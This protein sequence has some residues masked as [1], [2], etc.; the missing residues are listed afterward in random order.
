MKT[1]NL[2]YGFHSVLEALESDA[3]IDQIFIARGLEKKLI[4][5]KILELAKEKKVVVKEVPIEKLYSLTQK[6]HQGI[7]ATLTQITYASLEELVIRTYEKGENHL[8][9]IL[10]KITD[11]RNFGAIARSCEATG[12]T[13]IIIPERNS[14]SVTSDAI[15]ASAGALLHVPVARSS[16]LISAVKYLQKSGIK[17][18][19]TTDK[20]NKTY[21]RENFTLPVAFIFGNEERGISPELMKI[22]DDWISIPM[23]GHVESLNV[24][25]SAGIILYEV[26]RQRVTEE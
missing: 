8:F 13:G 16:N 10:D 9:V 24:S 11:V 5:R 7:V 26:I 18:Y 25:V 3:L 4:L 1:E 15:Q 19:A 12:V 2:I 17:V 6:N 21:Y 23:L 22:S 14:V 20:A